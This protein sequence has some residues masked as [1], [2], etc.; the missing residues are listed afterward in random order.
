MYNW[1]K[2]QLRLKR[3]FEA[4]LSLHKNIA[5]ADQVTASVMGR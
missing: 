1:T 5:G 3:N 4:T 2:Y